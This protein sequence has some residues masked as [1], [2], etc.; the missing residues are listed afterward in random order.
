MSAPPRAATPWGLVLLLGALTGAAPLSIGLTLPALPAMTADLH[1]TT[2]QVQSTVSAF[3]LGMGVGQ[4]FYGPAADRLGRRGPLFVGTAIY[5]IASIACLLATTPD[6]LIGMRFVQAFGGC[7]GGVIS[8]AIVRD[9][10]NHTE[11]ARMLS[12]MALITGVGPILAPM[13]GS[14]LLALGG[15]RTQFVVMAAFGL[16]MLVL[17]VLRLKESRTEET[18][19][20]SRTEGPLGAYLALLRERRL[21]GYALAGALNG[22]ALFTYIASSPDLL[23]NIYKISP[24][25]FG[26]VF[27]INGVGLLVSNQANRVLLR[28][29]GP[30]KI[31][32][33]SSLIAVGFAVLL[34]GAAMT[35]W[36]ERWS[37]LSL[38][39]A[40][41]ASFGFMQGNTMAGAL[42]VDPRRA[43]SAS[44]LMGF[45]SF[46]AGGIASAVAGLLHDGTAR[47]MALVTLV[48]LIGSAASLHF[49]ALRARP[50]PAVA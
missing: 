35:G 12:L 48:V 40:L 36:G 8:R 43:G 1:A 29:H 25:Q 13:L 10:F 44:A 5:M 28:R 9:Q 42:S 30:D 17:S 16:L 19:A 26:W 24:S 41:Q 15:W 34:V 32:R 38:L 20:H 4:L 49:L 22:A 23:I 50:A 6:M 3:L 45:A 47:P 11:T 46:A 31:L 21:M 27:G 39:F 2:G 14:L 37:V 18:I 7:A 33:T